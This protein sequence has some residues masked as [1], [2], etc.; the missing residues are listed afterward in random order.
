[1]QLLKDKLFEE[2]VDE[3]KENKFAKKEQDIAASWTSTFDKF[4]LFQD[5]VMYVLVNTSMCFE[6]DYLLKPTWYEFVRVA[7]VCCAEFC[8]FLMVSWSS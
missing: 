4:N 7:M 6:E 8:T 1:M 3:E 5:V 2:D